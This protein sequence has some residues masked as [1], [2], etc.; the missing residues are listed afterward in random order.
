[1]I[2]RTRPAGYYKAPNNRAILDVAKRINYD[3][4][5]SYSFVKDVANI[6]SHDKKADAMV[7]PYEWTEELERQVE[8]DPQYLTAKEKEDEIERRIDYHT[9]VQKYLLDLPM[10]QIKGSPIEKAFSIMAMLETTHGNGACSGEECGN[11]NGS[12]AMGNTSGPES[13]MPIFENSGQSGSSLAK[14]TLETIEVMNKIEPGSF[15]AKA[16]NVDGKHGA[17]RALNLSREQVSLLKQL[18]VFDKMEGLA[19]KK[20]KSEEEDPLSKTKEFV[21]MRKFSD[22]AKLEN[23]SVM[24]DPDFEEKMLKKSFYLEKGI[25]V[26]EVKQSLIMLID[27]SGSMNNYKKVGWVKALMLN[28]CNEVSKG[29]AEL[30]ICTFETQLDRTR[31]VVIRNEEQA[32]AA[33]KDFDNIFGFNRGGTDVQGVLE[34]TVEWID[35]GHVVGDDGKQHSFDGNRPQICIINDGQDRVDSTFIPRIETHAFILEGSNDNLKK[36][37]FRSGGTYSSF[38]Y[39]EMF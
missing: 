8:A 17:I 31:W 37:C 6:L 35:R 32:L 28:R 18:S 7:A 4:T 3:K 9:K 30:F 36:S 38:R 19:A 11:I 10:S 29:E 15:T 24:L 34:E 5:F 16:L 2:Q 22:I 1:M 14:D 25:K 23:K 13:F 12:S 26:K 21:R 39:D 27:D 20:I 33:W